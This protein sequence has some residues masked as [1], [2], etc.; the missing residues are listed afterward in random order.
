MKT[1]AAFGLVLGLVA[2]AFAQYP[3]DN[4][5]RTGFGNVVFPGTGGPPPNITDMTFAS[6]LGA[7]VS[8]FPPYTGAPVGSGFYGH[9]PVVYVP[10]VYP[11]Y[12]G[13]YYGY[14]PPVQQVPN[15]TIINQPPSAPQVIINQYAPPPEVNRTSNHERDSDSS[16]SDG[17]RSYQAPVRAQSDNDSAAETRYYLI[18]F[19]DSSI[20]SAIAYWV[21]GDKLHY[22][23]P[24]GAHNQASLDLVDRELTKRLNHDRKAEV[25][26]PGKSG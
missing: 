14:E 24:H 22:V 11:V 20:Y 5:L 15:I 10:Y 7:T 4:R 16:S 1:L 17:V 2:G 3:V 12:T 25:A 6:R 21:D 8:G 23:T 13:G 9:R 18:A 19:K 26:I